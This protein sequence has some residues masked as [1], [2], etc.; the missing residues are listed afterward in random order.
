MNF[1]SE[2]LQVATYGLYSAGKSKKQKT[3]KNHF[4]YDFYTKSILPC[5]TR[6]NEKTGVFVL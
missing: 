3:K 2:L 1:L 4:E 6:G 5:F